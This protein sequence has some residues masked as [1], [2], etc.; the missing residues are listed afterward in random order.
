MRQL[1]CLGLFSLLCSCG[2]LPE[3]TMP[4][5]D[6]AE[7]KIDPNDPPPKPEDAPP[8]EVP[9][10]ASLPS[11]YGYDTV[12]VRGRGEAFATVFVEGGKAPVA[13]DTDAAGNFCVD[14]PLK[15]SERQTLEVFVQDERGVTSDPAAKEI[16]Q[17]ASLAQYETPTQPLVNLAPGL[18]V[19]ADETPKDGLLRDATDGDPTTSVNMSKSFVWVDLGDLYDVETIE[20]IFPDQVGSGNDEFATEYL[21][22]SSSQTSPTL[23]PSPSSADWTVVYDIYPGSG[24]A[25]GDGGADTF[26]LPTPMR[27]RYI[28]FYLIENNKTDWFSSENIRF[29][30]LRIDGRSTEALP[31][32]PLIPTCANGRM[33]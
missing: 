23:P 21:V 26:A 25:A 4:A 7:E 32:Q 5:G 6:P 17:D 3:P 18:P 24:I 19:Y 2:A 20:I 10:L 14:V 33:P 30:E 22:M 29:A 31:A 12:P 16:T 28:A 8:P 9:T 27:T 1:L 13:T 11:R 15:E